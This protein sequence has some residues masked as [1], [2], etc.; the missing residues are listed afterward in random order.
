MLSISLDK[1]SY[2]AGEEVK[3]AIILSLG[4][5]KKARGLF[6]SLICIERKQVKTTVVLDKYEFDRDRELGQPYA[7]HMETR[8][9]LREKIFYSREAKIS[10]EGSYSSGEFTVSFTLPQ[11]A[12]PTSHELGHDNLIHVW[13]VKAKLDIPLAPDE[14]AEAEVVVEGL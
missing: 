12:P 10:G 11:N 4:S 9:E 7:S 13:K 5:E 1:P 3:A 14:N 8:N 6:A 2:S